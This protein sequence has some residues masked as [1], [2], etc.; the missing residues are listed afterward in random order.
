MSR[1]P[2]IWYPGAMYHVTA[3]G[4]RRG[5][6]FYDDADFEEYKKLMVWC[7]KE[8]PFLLHAYCLMTNHVHLLIETLHLPL[9]ESIKALHSRYAIYFNKRHKVTGHLF[10]GR[11]HA[12]LIDTDQY[13]L[14]ASKYIHL[15]P[16]E[17]K[18][19]ASAAAYPFSS[20]AAY[21][22]PYAEEACVRTEKILS[23]FTHP[24]QEK[25]QAYV[26]G[27][28]GDPYRDYSKKHWT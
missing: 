11:Y 23:L 7:Q 2:R 13:F 14:Q 27:K 18:M 21:L 16:L 22:D 20:Y 9:G 19:V 10:Q 5:D 17:A 3:R 26:N 25:Y 4:N 24:A 6:L 12:T 28:D 8:V 1:K 15:N